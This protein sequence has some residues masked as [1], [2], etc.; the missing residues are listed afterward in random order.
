MVVASGIAKPG[1]LLHLG[2][3]RRAVRRQYNCSL[4]GC[5]MRDI[6]GADTDSGDVL[7]LH[8]DGYMNCEKCGKKIP[9]SARFCPHCGSAV[10]G[11]ADKDLRKSCQ[12]DLRAYEEY[13]EKGRGSR[14][15]LRENHAARLKD[16][17]R[18]A[19][20]DIWQGQWL[21]G[22]CYE[23]GLGVELSGPAAVDYLLKAAEAGYARA[24]NYIGIC[25][26]DG[27]NLPEDPAEAAEWFRKSAEQGFALAAANL[28]WCYDAGSGVETDPAA[29]VRWYEQAAGAG[30]ATAQFNLA[31]HYEQGL[32]VEQDKAAA[33]T[34]FRKAAEQGFDRAT[35]E[36]ERLTEDLETEQ[37]F[38][39]KR[40]EQAEFH[41]RSACKDALVKGAES[42]EASEQL[43]ERARILKLPRDNARRLFE[44]EKEM[45]AGQE[46][47]LVSKDSQQQFR[48][49]CAKAI[50]DGEVTVEEREKLTK[51]GRSLNLSK[52]DIK[53]IFD[54][55]KQRYIRD[56]EKQ[57]A[58]QGYEKFRQACRK[59]IADGR[60]T[61]G[62]SKQ[63]KTLAQ[64][65]RLSRRTVQQLF[66]EEKQ[67][68]F[69]E[70]GRRKE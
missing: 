14:E 6:V 30:D 68:Y 44:Q 57:R 66:D 39:E 24:Q 37:Q 28:G 12:A 60:V 15:Y 7:V 2:D 52:E 50:A 35:Q 8:E 53:R 45:H 11:K 64:S 67:K 19:D 20:V 51:M 62:E 46:R 32:G 70:R 31:V 13:I 18:A 9:G 25:Y 61:P 56:F 16:W 10:A 40:L 23:E 22:R 48:T 1:L 21:L 17:Q 63:L 29:A 47:Q 69:K 54:E 27:E 42:F 5:W 36:A 55:E 33:L 38:A 49:L 3:G 59:A 34:W 43:Q 41:F 26:R 65:L 4:I 58:Q